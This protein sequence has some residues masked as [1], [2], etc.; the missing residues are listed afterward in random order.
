MWWVLEPAVGRSQRRGGWFGGAHYLASLLTG[1][2]PALSHIPST[3]VWQRKYFHSWRGKGGKTY[4]LRYITGEVVK[5]EGGKKNP[6]CIFYCTW[7]N[8]LSTKAGPGKSLWMV[9]HCVLLRSSFPMTP[10]VHVLMLMTGNLSIH[11]VGLAV[12]WLMWENSSWF[13][14]V[15]PCCNDGVDDDEGTTKVHLPEM[16][17]KIKSKTRNEEEVSPSLNWW[18]FSEL[19]LCQPKL[20][21][22]ILSQTIY[23]IHKYR[24]Q[25]CACGKW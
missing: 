11:Y 23:Y 5:T 10:W 14:S 20:C 6:A 22:H 4:V 21:G 15:T 25:I 16:A 8:I 1:S 7:A 24:S 9:S 18:V 3:D 13:L 2:G 12:L 19:R 17:A